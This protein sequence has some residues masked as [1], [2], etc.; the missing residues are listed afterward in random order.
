M[1]VFMLDVKSVTKKCASEKQLENHKKKF[2]EGPK[3]F[4]CQRCDEKFCN[5]IE[6]YMHNR[7]NHSDCKYCGKVFQ[8]TTIGMRILKTHIKYVH[9]GIKN[10][11][12]DTCGKS[13]FSKWDMKRHVDSVHL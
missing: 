3:K 2:H 13:F 8:K 5:K 4:Q 7:N 1:K 12:C 9:E 10:H 6:W 11:T